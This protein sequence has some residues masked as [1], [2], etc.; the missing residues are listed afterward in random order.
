MLD[1]IKLLA[2]D[3]LIYGVFTVL[4]RF[5]SFLLT[6]LY[7]N[8]LSTSALADI[9]N[10]Y[11]IIAFMNIIYS[12]GMETAFFR[13]Y[14]KNNLEKSRTVFSHS[15]LSILL[16][17]ALFSL[18]FFFNAKAIAPSLTSLDNGAELIRL[19][20]ILPFIDALML[21]PFGL[22]RMVRKA[23]KFAILKFI[24]IL[25]AFGFNIYFVVVVRIGASGVLIAQII[26]SSIGV[27]LV[28]KELI[29][30]LRFKINFRLF[31][32]MLK[33]GLPTLPAN[34]S[35]IILQVADRP[36]LM[37]M[38]TVDQVAAY[39][40]SYRLGIPMMIFVTVFEYA[41]KPFYLNHFEEENSDKLFARILTY[42][43]LIAAG[44]FLVFS[45]Y[46]KYIVRMPFIGGRFINPEY[47][48]S[49]GIIP[50]I[51]G[52]YF[53]NG[54]FTNFAAGFI[55]TKKT[56]II[57]VAIGLA[58]AVN[59]G[60]NFMLIP[61]I[62]FWGAAWATLGAYFTSALLLYI[63]ARKIYPL[64]YE[65]KRIAVIVASTLIV[66]FTA[67]YFSQNVEL[68]TAFSIKTAA[69]IGFFILLKVAGFFNKEE[70]NGIK[71]LFRRK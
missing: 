44:I 48:Y 26:A 9:A 65:W 22:M 8:Y 17:S 42:F 63:L 33:F 25:L 13:F 43:T 67:N 20:A 24:V 12:F 60:M 40:V 49:L 14:D 55:I 70:I 21:I 30:N 46:I 6:P 64:P 54:L 3:T 10:I 41:W 28:S 38:T 35:A 71:R 36:L 59:L 31:W 7:T 4:G 23:K 15:F 52:G 57:P 68:W 32:D 11:A 39:Q 5:L 69:I 1:K 37:S 18:I 56:K 16:I 53:F 66:Y 61:V 34:L 47:W 50:I 58:A 27:I 45:L 29:Q 2:S 62:G 51:L 19:A